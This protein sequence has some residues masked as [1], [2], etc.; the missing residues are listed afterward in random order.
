[1]TSP[2]RERI[3]LG[4]VSSAILRGDEDLSLWSEE[5]LLRG[6]RKDKNGRWA[7]RPPKVVPKAVHDE[8]VRRKMSKAHD[9]LRDNLVAA[10][11][12]L[13]GI[14]KDKRAQNSD[15]LKAASLIMDRVLGKVPDH[16][17]LT[18]DQEPAWAKAIRAGMVQAI[19]A[20][21]PDDDDIAL[22]M[23]GRAL[24]AADEEGHAGDVTYVGSRRRRAQ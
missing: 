17:V 21:A 7:G 22:P 15:R 18:E 20:Q 13:V 9:L 14:A 12:V 2:K 23:P 3:Q 1:M 16:V 4:Q 11:E 24:P 19:I 6:T 10:V 8:L 5:E